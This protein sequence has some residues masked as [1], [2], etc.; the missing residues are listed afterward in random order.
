[1]KPLLRMTTVF[2]LL[3]CAA[4]AQ[5]QA[6]LD[7][8]PGYWEKVSSEKKAWIALN[9]GLAPEEETRFWPLYAGYQ[10][11]L[12]PFSRRLIEALQTYARHYREQSL[13]DDMAMKLM[14]E[15]LAIEESEVQLRKT[16]ADRLSKVL[17]GRKAAR[18]IQLESRIRTVI[19]FELAQVFPL[20]GDTPG[21]HAITPV[22]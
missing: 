19:R 10:K 12:E 17:P 6:S 11:A 20:A 4:V 7:L 3:I 22:K 14:G 9:M 1:M 18:Y 8:P 16:Y 15:L 2:L 13:T 5:A 21:E